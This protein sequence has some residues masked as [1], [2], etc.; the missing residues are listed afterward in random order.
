V[1]GGGSSIPEV[2][3]L[4]ATLAVG[5]RCAEAGTAFGGGAA[6]IASTARSLVTVEAD[7][8]RAEVAR[9]RLRGFSN[10]ELVVGDWHVELP[11]RAP[12]DLL[13]LD[14]GGFKQAPSREGPDALALLAPAGMLVV[15]DL[16]PG[17]GTHD[18]A[19]AFLL[20]HPGLAAVEIL[21]TPGTAAIVA[22][23]LVS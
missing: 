23:A 17:R 13:F 1:T 6:A 18:P 21:T 7:E 15:D 4:L 2:Q 16:T 20:G 14:G 22:A 12:F 11:A 3:A 8:G 10:V 19:R 5:K 9:E